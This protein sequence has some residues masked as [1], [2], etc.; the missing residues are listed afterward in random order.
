MKLSSFILLVSCF[1]YLNLHAVSVGAVS[2]GLKDSLILKRM[3]IAGEKE[4]IICYDVLNPT[5]N[6]TTIC[7]HEFH[8]AC[9][10]DFYQ[11]KGNRECPVCRQTPQL[12]LYNSIRDGNILSFN[13]SLDSGVFISTDTYPLALAA[14]YGRL[15]IIKKLINLGA[16]VNVLTE[17]YYIHEFRSFH[18]QIQ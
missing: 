3:E 5:N 18:P 13:K 14:R 15:D 6:I 1:D 10:L 8:Q 12:F 9:L 16:N 17:A 4:C 2:V 11:S 7:G